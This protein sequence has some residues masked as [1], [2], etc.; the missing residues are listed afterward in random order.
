MT[1]IFLFD[2]STGELTINTYEILLIKEF[3]IL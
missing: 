1:D 2:N 3:A